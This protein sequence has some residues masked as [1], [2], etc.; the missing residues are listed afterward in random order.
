MAQGLSSL[1]LLPLALLTRLLTL[2]LQHDPCL[3]VGSGTWHVGWL[4]GKGYKRLCL[5]EA[6]L[7]SI[8]IPGLEFFFPS[9]S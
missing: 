2:A 5:G 4:Q 9:Q 7:W 8:M 3:P 6:G 1:G